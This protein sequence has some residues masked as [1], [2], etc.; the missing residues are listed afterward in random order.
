MIVAVP[1]NQFAN[2]EPGSPQ[3]IIDFVQRNYDPKMDEKLV[4]VTKGDVNGPKTRP[5][6][7]W[8]KQQ[9]PERDGSLDIPWNFS[10]FLVDRQGKAHKRYAPQEE[11][12]N[13]APD[14]ERLISAS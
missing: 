4:F 8:L 1:C 2:E 9:R 5:L 13:V 14:I 6:Y 7:V 10:K 12:W 11:P 3:E